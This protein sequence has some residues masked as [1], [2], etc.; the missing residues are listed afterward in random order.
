MNR[1]K[2]TICFCETKQQNPVRIKADAER[3]H[4]EKLVYQTTDTKRNEMKSSRE[5]RKGLVASYPIEGRKSDWWNQKKRCSYLR[6][7]ETFEGGDG[8]IAKRNAGN[9]RR[10]VSRRYKRVNLDACFER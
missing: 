1:K 10:G 7:G 6:S 8:R 5:K 2:S 9:N 3:S 4:K